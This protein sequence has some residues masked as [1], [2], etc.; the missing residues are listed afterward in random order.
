MEA[1]INEVQ[2]IVS[3]FVT[4]FDRIFSPESNLLVDAESR[5]EVQLAT[6]IFE[7]PNLKSFLFCN[8]P[9]LLK[10]FRDVHNYPFKHKLSVKIRLKSNYF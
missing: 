6:L 1:D 4:D 10:C 2:Q 5:H 7:R 3:V 9:R 8:D